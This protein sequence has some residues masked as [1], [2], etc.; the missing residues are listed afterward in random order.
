MEALATAKRREHGSLLVG[1]RLRCPRCHTENDILSYFSFDR[2]P[3]H[4]DELNVVLKCRAKVR[5]KVTGK[6]ESCRCI[7]SVSDPL[8]VPDE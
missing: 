3:E 4:E 1:H 6:V 7:F 8:E 2:P 5:H